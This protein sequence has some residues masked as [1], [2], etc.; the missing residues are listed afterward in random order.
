MSSNLIELRVG[1]RYKADQ[2]RKLSGLLKRG[3]LTRTEFERQKRDVLGPPG[4]D[5]EC[6]R[7][8]SLIA[9]ALAMLAEPEAAQDSSAANVVSFE[10]WKPGPA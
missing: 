7:G 10:K 6:D 5:D 9:E 1:G 4:N 3:L 8:E 2:L